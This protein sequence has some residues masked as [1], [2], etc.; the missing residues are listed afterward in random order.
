MSGDGEVTAEQPSTEFK[1]GL[2]TDR[3]AT[4]TRSDGVVYAVSTKRP[5][6]DPR[7][8]RLDGTLLQGERRSIH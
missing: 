1:V 2:T 6:S 3:Y 4:Y 7:Q 8:R 5:Q